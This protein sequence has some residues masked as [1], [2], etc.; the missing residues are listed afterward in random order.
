MGLDFRKRSGR[1]FDGSKLNVDG[2][3]IYNVFKG[4]SFTKIAPKENQIGKP[5]SQLITPTPTPNPTN[6][7]TP[8]ITPTITPTNTPT[9]TPTPTPS[10]TPTI[11]STNT[12]TPTQTPTPTPTPACNCYLFTNLDPINNI[13]FSYLD[14]NGTPSKLIIPPLGTS[15]YLCV[16]SYTPDINLNVQNFGDCNGSTPCNT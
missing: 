16:Q 5:L 8:S 3:G 10:I 14:C 2:Q 12:P 13:D 11:T 7:P 6:T 1:V 15:G 9:S 4:S